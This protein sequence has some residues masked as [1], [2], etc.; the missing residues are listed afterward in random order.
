MVLGLAIALPVLLGSILL[1]SP[2]ANA[3][4]SSGEVEYYTVLAGESLW[5][6]AQTIAPEHDPRQVIDE[7]LSLNG[8]SSA[9]VYPGDQL[10]LPSQY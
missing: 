5:E 3:G 6:I 8:L 2:G 7:I 4:S 1:V 9:E 10:A